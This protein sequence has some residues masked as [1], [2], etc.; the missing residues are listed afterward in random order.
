MR[1]WRVGL[2]NMLSGPHGHDVQAEASSRKWLR[3]LWRGMPMECGRY[4]VGLD[5]GQVRSS[6]CVIDDSGTVLRE[7]DCD[8]SAADIE[9]VLAVGPKGSN[10]KVA[11]EVGCGTHL[12]RKLR[13]RGY[14][15]ALLETRKLK[16]LLEIRR[17]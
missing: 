3:S 1:H 4:W 8:T 12:S 11:M 6:V 13:L 10:E 7:C 9:A 16:R 17:N 15:V 2:R 14:E 5:I